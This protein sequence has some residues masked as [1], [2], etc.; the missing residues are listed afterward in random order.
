MYERRR[1]DELAESRFRRLERKVDG[2]DTKVDALSTK[3]ALIA[4][5]LAVLSF[6]F[7]IIG[8]IVADR[9]IK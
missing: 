9:V 2:L 1:A 5:G 8:P 4:G 7:N 3:L 6:L